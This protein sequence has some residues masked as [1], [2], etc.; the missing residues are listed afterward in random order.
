[1]MVH[2]DEMAVAL[3]VIHK[4]KQLEETLD[5]GDLSGYH[6]GNEDGGTRVEI[7]IDETHVGHVAW[8]QRHDG[9]AYSP[10]TGRDVR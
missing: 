8:S 2:P 10:A 4:L 3:A 7:F 5:R 1:M 9:W 6:L